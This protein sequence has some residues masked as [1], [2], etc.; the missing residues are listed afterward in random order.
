MKRFLHVSIVWLDTA[1]Q[2]SQL[3]PILDLAEDWI[4]YGAS[5]FILYTQEDVLTWQGR[6]MAV[7][8][9]STDRFFISVI[10]DV[11]GTGGFLDEYIWNWLR[12]QRFDGSLYGT[13]LSPPR[14]S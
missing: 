6:F 10:T 4:T 5:N 9:I 1:K 7:I 13:L 14:P 12:Q 8:N 3:R 11:H 2:P